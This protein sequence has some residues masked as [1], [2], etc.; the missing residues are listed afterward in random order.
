MKTT[1]WYHGIRDE[2]GQALL[3]VEERDKDMRVVHRKPLDDRGGTATQDGVEWSFSGSGPFHCAQAIVRDLLNPLVTGN[4]VSATRI[5]MYILVG[6]PR[7]EWKLPASDFAQYL[8][9]RDRWRYRWRRLTR[10][11]KRK[12][13]DAI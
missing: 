12:D 4:V 5:M 10:T 3:F 6:L 7:G 1:K 13:I 2:F 8:S 11:F 9:W